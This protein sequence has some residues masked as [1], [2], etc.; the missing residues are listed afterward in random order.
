MNSSIQLKIVFV[1]IILLPAGCSRLNDEAVA[2]AQAQAARAE[3]EA[4]REMAEKARADAEAARAQAAQPAPVPEGLRIRRD[5]EAEELLKLLGIEADCFK[6]EGDWIDCWIEIDVDGKQ[7]T[8]GEGRGEIMRLAATKNVAGEPGVGKPSGS[9][10]WVR[11]SQNKDEVWDLALSGKVKIAG[12]EERSSSTLTLGPPNG[13]PQPRVVRAQRLLRGDAEAVLK[14][15]QAATLV[16]QLSLS[17]KAGDITRTV[18]LQCK[19]LK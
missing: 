18:K 4:V 5:T 8:W 9:M 15:G 16:T 12:G 7:S 6:Y 10:V 1:M 13:P 14:N 11:R 2:R 3:A 17:D 19:P